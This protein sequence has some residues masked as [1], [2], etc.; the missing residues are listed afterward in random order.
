MLNIEPDLFELAGVTD[1][2]GAE[3]PKL[4][5]ENAEKQVGSN[6]LQ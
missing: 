6:Q 4:S 3:A 1:F 5:R 2:D